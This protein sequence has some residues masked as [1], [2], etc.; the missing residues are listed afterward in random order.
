MN[1]IKE[2]LLKSK[3]ILFEINSFNIRKYEQILFELN[4]YLKKTCKRV[5]FEIE[6]QF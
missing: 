1:M 2:K 5:V 3:T 4:I 6:F